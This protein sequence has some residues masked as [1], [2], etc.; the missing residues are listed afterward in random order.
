MLIYFKFSGIKLKVKYIVH[1]K[2][3]SRLQDN[4]HPPFSND[5]GKNNTIQG[6]TTFGEHHLKPYVFENF[7]RTYYVCTLFWECLR[8]FTKISESCISSPT[9]LVPVEQA[10][11]LRSTLWCSLF[12]SPNSL[13][14]RWSCSHFTRSFSL[15][16]GGFNEFHSSL[17]VSFWVMVFMM[18]FYFLSK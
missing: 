15:I 5:P 12:P 6:C 13:F 9:V 2:S 14:K 10:T 17:A 4:L 3:A 8:I 7:S 16:L 1:T 11:L 18:D